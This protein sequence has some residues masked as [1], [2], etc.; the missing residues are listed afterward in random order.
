[1]PL[2]KLANLLLCRWCKKHGLK[3]NT[4]Q[5]RIYG[6]GRPP[7]LPALRIQAESTGQARGPAPTAYLNGIG[8]KSGF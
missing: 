8:V 4:I 7:C 1:M 2:P 5:I 6:R 3:S